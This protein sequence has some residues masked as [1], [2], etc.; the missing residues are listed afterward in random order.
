MTWKITKK[1]GGPVTIRYSVGPKV[2]VVTET[3]L[4]NGCYWGASVSY[5][6]PEIG[7]ITHASMLIGPLFT[8]STAAV[9]WC[10]QYLANLEIR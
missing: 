5:S 4:D 7:A 9:G 3:P 10:E 2:A 6:E 8:T 1:S